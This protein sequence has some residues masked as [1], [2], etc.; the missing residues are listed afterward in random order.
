MKKYFI[1][2]TFFLKYGFLFSQ[3]RANEFLYL[4]NDN[5]RYEMIDSVEIVKNLDTILCLNYYIKNDVLK[6]EWYLNKRLT[7][8]NNYHKPLN[9]SVS[10]HSSGTVSKIVFVDSSGKGIVQTYYES[11]RLKSYSKYNCYDSLGYFVEY[12]ENGFLRWEVFPQKVEEVD[13]I[14]HCNGRLESTG[15]MMNGHV[16]Y[17]LWKFYDENGQLI[18]EGEFKKYSQQELQG[19]AFFPQVIETKIGVWYYYNPKGHLY[20]QEKYDQDGNLKRS[21]LGRKKR[22]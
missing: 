2:L 19:M 6:Q 18:A 9:I 17:G 7:H 11:G 14:Y 8:V 4:L 15:E 3:E 12:C 5:F 1:V 22:W 10:W 16:R 20:K 13:S 21:I